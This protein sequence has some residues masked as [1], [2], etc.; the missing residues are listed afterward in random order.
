MARQGT[1]AACDEG[2]VLP[3]WQVE[4]GVL[5]NNMHCRRA[6]SWQR[7]RVHQCW[8]LLLRGRIWTWRYAACS[9][10]LV[11]VLL[12]LVLVLLLLVLLLTWMH[13]WGTCAV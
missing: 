8:T 13:D 10:L 5:L 1:A 2:L 6:H 11:L 9:V 7:T 3:S 4:V 12:V